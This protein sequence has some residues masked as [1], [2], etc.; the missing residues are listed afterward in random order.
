MNDVATT[1]TL[2]HLLMGLTTAEQLAMLF[3]VMGALY[4]MGKAMFAV[5]QFFATLSTSVTSLTESV[6]SLKS[7][8]D[9]HHEK[10]HSQLDDI[11]ERV[12]ALEHDR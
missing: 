4:A 2:L 8:F 7:S 12:Y 9:E 3:A 5:A 10:I 1:P 11:Q 6:K